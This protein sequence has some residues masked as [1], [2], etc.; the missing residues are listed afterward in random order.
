MALRSR[1]A[2]ALNDNTDPTLTPEQLAASILSLRE[3]MESRFNGMDQATKL[4]HESMSRVP[5]D[6]D[7]QVTHVRELHNE[8]FSSIQKQFDER[9]IRSKAAED[10]AKIAVN[11]ALQAQKEAAAAQNESN[12]VAVKKSEDAVVKQIDGILALIA[13][14]TKAGD[15]KISDLKG[16]MDRG[17]GGSAGRAAGGASLIAISGLAI[18]CVAA[19]FSIV[20][21][22]H[23]PAP[24]PPV[25][26]LATPAIR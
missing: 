12:A 3:L 4:L 25:L 10:A 21:V 26:A 16:R 22:L 9:D 15:D 2:A 1:T 20:N 7:K 5:S 18:A 8:R 11:A 23:T 24:P 13:S 17:E 19:I 14:G 6:T